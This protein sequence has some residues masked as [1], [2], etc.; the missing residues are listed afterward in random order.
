MDNARRRPVVLPCVPSNVCGDLRT[1]VTLIIMAYSTIIRTI[2]IAIA[3]SH[4]TGVS[5]K[6]IGMLPRMDVHTITE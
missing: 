5:A 6:I 1:N 3:I 2:E 4:P